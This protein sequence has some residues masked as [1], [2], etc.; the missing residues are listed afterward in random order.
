MSGIPFIVSD[1]I[2]NPEKMST[3]YYFFFT[4]IAEQLSVA[5]CLE[6]E[7]EKLDK[8]LKICKNGIYVK[9]LA[10]Q[11]PDNAFRNIDVHCEG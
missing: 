10:P 6:K 4:D 7:N 8:H 2:L 11:S 9:R 1:I 5:G 3:F